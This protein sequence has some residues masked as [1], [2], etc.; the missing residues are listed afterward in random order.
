[1]V[2]ARP[3]TIGSEGWV[4]SSACTEDFSSMHSTIAF[5]GGSREPD[6]V[7]EFLLELRVIRQLERLHQVR[8]EPPRGPDPLHRGR[9]DPARLRHGTARPVRLTVRRLLPG[10]AHDP[11]DLLRRDRRLSPPT[12]ADLPE[13]GQA[14]V[15]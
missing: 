2:P 4:R 12:G 1:M 15:F 5:S 10:T 3:L 8:L 6:H 7:D 11:G 13:P 9:A 14:F